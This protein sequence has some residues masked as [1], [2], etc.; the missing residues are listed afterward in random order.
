MVGVMS[1]MA[2]AALW[3]SGPA[4]PGWV[5]HRGLDGVL[6]LG[7]LGFVPAPLRLH[8]AIAGGASLGACL[9]AGYVV[10]RNAEGPSAWARPS[11][12]R[13]NAAELRRASRRRARSKSVETEQREVQASTAWS[14]AWRRS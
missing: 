9:Y 11:K 3:L 6:W 10:Q 2:P 7:G 8:W 12:R 1:L 5:G 13:R 14:R 4:A